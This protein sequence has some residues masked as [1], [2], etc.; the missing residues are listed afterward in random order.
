EKNEA[1][2]R[3]V[4]IGPSLRVLEPTQL[5]DIKNNPE[6]V[7][8]KRLYNYLLQLA[9]SIDLLANNSFK[10]SVSVCDSIIQDIEV[11]GDLKRSS[12]EAAEDNFHLMYY[13]VT[14]LLESRANC[15]TVY[16]RI[17]IEALEIRGSGKRTYDLKGSLK[18]LNRVIE[19]C[20][21]YAHAR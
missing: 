9:K 4:S 1:S 2:D 18:D 15:G 21:G 17:Y 13:D 5:T 10:G 3:S 16:H 11:N 6:T 8:D 7:N 14:P 19:L 12:R 20:P